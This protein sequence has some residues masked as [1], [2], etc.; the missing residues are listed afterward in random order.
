MSSGKFITNDG[1][2]LKE[3][4]DLTIPRTEY[5]KFLVW[6]FYFSWF[7]ELYNKIWDRPMKVIVWMDVEVDIKNYIK[8]WYRLMD[9]EDNETI[10]KHTIDNMKTRFNEDEN[11]DTYEQDKA[12]RIFIDKIKNN[13]LEIYRTKEPNHSKLYIFKYVEDETTRQGRDYW[14]MILWSSNFTRSGLEWRFEFNAEFTDPDDVKKWE[15]MFDQLL[16]ESVKI[17]EWWEDDPLVKIFETKTR[18]K[19]PTPYLCYLKVLSEYFSIEE[20]ELDMPSQITSNGDKIFNDYSYQVDAIKQAYSMLEVH[21]WVLI[22][23]VVW[24]GKSIIWATLLRNLRKK[25]LIICKPHLIPQWKQYAEDFRLTSG[26]HT[27]VMSSGALDKVV[28][29]LEKETNRDS[30]TQVVMIDEA[31]RFRN[32]LTKD[33]AYLQKICQWKKVILLTATPF[34][35]QP[36][37]VFNLIKLFQIPKRPTI[38]TM[39]SLNA[40]FQEQQRM[41]VKMKDVI[42]WKAKSK[43]DKKL[44]KEEWEQKLREVSNKI[45]E[46]IRPF[47]IRRTRKDLENSSRYMEDLKSQWFKKFSDVMAPQDLNYDLWNIAEEYVE[48]LDELL[49]RYEWLTDW[50]VKKLKERNFKCA[51]YTPLLYLKWD[52]EKEKYKKAF[53]K[54][55]GYDYKFLEWRQQN[56]PLFITRQLVSRFESCVKGF[57]VSLGNVINNYE[58]YIKYIETNNQVP[59]ISWWQ[60]SKLIKLTEQTAWSQDDDDDYIDESKLDYDEEKERDLRDNMINEFL[61]THKWIT[62]DLKDLDPNFVPYLKSDL[63]FLQNIYDRWIDIYGENFD[64]EDDNK[65]EELKKLIIDKMTDLSIEKQKRKVVIFSQYETTVRYLYDKL[66][67]DFKKRVLRV[68]WGNKD[69]KL[70][71][72]ISENFDASA[73]VQKDDYDIIVATDSISE[74]FNLHRAWLVINYDIPWNP[75]VIIQRVW[76]INRIDRTVFDQLYIYNAFPSLEGKQ[77]YQV[78][79]VVKIKNEMINTIFWSDTKILDENETLWSFY[80]RLLE[81]D[82]QEEDEDPINEFRN[83]YYELCRNNKKDID[84]AKRLPIKSKCKRENVEVDWEKK[85]WMLVF[86]KKWK[87]CVFKFAWA[88]DTLMNLDAYTWMKMFRAETSEPWKQISETAYKEIYPKIVR[89]LFVSDSESEWDTKARKALVNLQ[90]YRAEFSEDYYEELSYCIADLGIISPRHLRMIRNI[91]DQN[92]QE[93]I[94]DL[95]NELT[96][97]D[98]RK[99]RRIAEWI[100]DQDKTIVLAEEF[101]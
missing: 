61:E 86:W 63:K 65:Y 26:M 20:S 53:E 71:Q 30:K 39:K 42:R 32:G 89:K 93:K 50:N 6:Y 99:M 62:V 92:K 44:S 15:A 60:L 27:E 37:D 47:T 54:N 59:V 72:E 82:K 16:E 8:E 41:Y 1:E 22:A 5:M 52:A 12:I 94:K 76:R 69:N 45:R 70:I 23:D 19:I 64:K 56:M 91:T 17:T 18:I 9:H 57:I 97:S 73:R 28:E 101:I 4:F 87:Q 66:S 58:E 100:D 14:T 85:E 68:S 36:D 13:T 3:I 43:E 95:M 10:K 34:N 48:T 55:Y 40:E 49:E 11:A 25:S 24:M 46:L 90:K 83:F 75:T 2:T 38:V 77:I 29:Y 7:Q 81:A 88:D 21:N 96:L 98:L 79:D 51:R 31:H 84:E 67:K 35:N 33:Y 80:N 78:E 74:W